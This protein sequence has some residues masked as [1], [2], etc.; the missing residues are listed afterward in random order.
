ML[1]GQEFVTRLQRQTHATQ[2]V[3]VAEARKI[4]QQATDAARIARPAVTN[5]AYGSP[6]A[7]GLVTDSAA[8]G[9]NQ[10]ASTRRKITAT[11]NS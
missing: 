10:A 6:P 3:T 2:T 8:L 11:A 9:G 7:S 1:N 5:A 4:Q